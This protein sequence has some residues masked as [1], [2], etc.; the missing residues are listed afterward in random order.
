M[1]AFQKQ[2]LILQFS[3]LEET[4]SLALTLLH[5]RQRFGSHEPTRR[6]EPLKVETQQ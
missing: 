6:A 4:A 5:M 1:K 2:S 3:I